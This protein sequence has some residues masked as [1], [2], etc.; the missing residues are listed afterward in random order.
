MASEVYILPNT[1]LSIIGGK[2]VPSWQLTIAVVSQTKKSSTGKTRVRE[3]LICSESNTY[4]GVPSRMKMKEI[5][6]QQVCG[7]S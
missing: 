3:G 6:I 1:P 7:G 4:R 5:P 2:I